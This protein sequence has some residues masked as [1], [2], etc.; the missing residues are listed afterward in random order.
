MAESM[1]KE[2]KDISFPMQQK[3][4]LF[5]FISYSRL[6]NNFYLDNE[7]EQIDIKNPC[8]PNKELERFYQKILKEFKYLKNNSQENI[9]FINYISTVD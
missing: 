9:F 2:L 8:F 4:K 7:I 3:I 6:R 1:E 5:A